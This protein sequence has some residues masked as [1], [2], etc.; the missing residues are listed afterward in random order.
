MGAHCHWLDLREGDWSQE[1]GRAA[2]RRAL[3]AI[4]ATVVY[5]PSAIDYHPEHRRVAETLAAVLCASG[6]APDVRLYAIQVPLT[7]LLTNLIHDVSDLEDPIRGVLSSYPSQRQTL[8]SASRLR[9]YAARFYGTGT[10]VEGFC[11]MP[12]SLY[13]SLHRRPQARF[14]GLENR[15]WMDP[16]TL[17][18]GMPERLS[19]S[20]LAQANDRLRV[21]EASR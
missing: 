8:T 17:V 16:L 14:R 13:G 9:R 1:S 2:L 20:R 19:W 7:P 10:Q 12:A 21:V 18:V 4:D 3:E 5:A 6:L 15:A 11:A